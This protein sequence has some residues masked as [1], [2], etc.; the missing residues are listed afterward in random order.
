ME[1]NRQ[2]LYNM[3]VGYMGMRIYFVS[4]GTCLA[5]VFVSLCL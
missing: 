3:C 2:L 1:V 5:C 4:E